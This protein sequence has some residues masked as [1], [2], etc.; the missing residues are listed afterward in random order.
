MF[1]LKANALFTTPTNKGV[2]ATFFPSADGGGGPQVRAP[3][4]ALPINLGI[5]GPGDLVPSSATVL[6][7]FAVL[8]NNRRID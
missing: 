2:D 4:D 5:W 6:G 1:K 3:L 8:E 7:G